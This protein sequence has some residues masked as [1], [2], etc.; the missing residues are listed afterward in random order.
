MRSLPIGIQANGIRDR[1]D[2]PSPDP[3]TALTMVRDCGLFDYVEKTPSDEEFAAFATA[4][5]KTGVP[6]RCGGWYYTLKRDEP[7]LQKHLH[8]A[9]TLGTK[10]QNVQVL[11]HDAT[12]RP[13]SDQEV[14]DF[15]QRA[16]EWGDRAGVKI[17]FEVHV[18]MWSEDFRRVSRVARLVEDA[19]L[20]FRL[21][22][23]HSHVIFKIDH[24][25][26]QERGGIRED[27]E[28]GRLELDPFKPESVTQHWIASNWVA[29]AHAR[30]VI[31]NNPRNWGYA[32]QDGNPGRGIQY[33]IKEP[34]PGEFDEDWRGDRL[35]PWKEVVRQLF[36]WHTQNAD[37][38][39]GQVTTEYIPS[40]DYG[41]GCRYSLFD[42]SQACA[43]WLRQQWEAAV[44]GQSGD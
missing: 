11:T 29:H 31:P 34:G 15:Y 28:S 13:I 8:Q 35:E 5:E 39:L 42:Q 2:D 9:E 26:E 17:A 24:P 20:A 19:G 3:M 25:D 7:L 23:D 16:A 43:S 18:N 4:S 30:P 32:D 12:G 1:A 6:I 33:P 10:L 38:P 22:L 40:P 14:A 37:S 36:R 41:A 21:T 27:V 44:A